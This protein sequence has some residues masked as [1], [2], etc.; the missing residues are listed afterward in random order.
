MGGAGAAVKSVK[1]VGSDGMA[2]TNRFRGRRITISPKTICDGTPACSGLVA[3]KTYYV[4][5]TKAGLL[6]DRIGTKLAQVDSKTTWSFTTTL[7]QTKR[8]EVDFL[9]GQ[10]NGGGAWAGMAATVT[11]YIYF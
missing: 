5:T 11:G 7:D 1:S 10:D 6:K 8:P 9:G 2:A 4:K 3:S